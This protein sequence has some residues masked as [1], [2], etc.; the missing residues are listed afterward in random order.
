VEC[1]PVVQGGMSMN[2]SKVRTRVEQH[3]HPETRISRGHGIT[4]LSMVRTFLPFMEDGR[5]GMVETLLSGVCEGLATA[6][7]HT[8]CGHPALRF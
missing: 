2:S 7:V 6:L 5:A 1:T 8:L 4:E 3:F